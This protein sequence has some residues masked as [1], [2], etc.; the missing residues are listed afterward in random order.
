MVSIY[1]PFFVGR[2]MDLGRLYKVKN[3]ISKRFAEFFALAFFVLSLKL[4]KQ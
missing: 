1:W 2:D 3:L 4:G